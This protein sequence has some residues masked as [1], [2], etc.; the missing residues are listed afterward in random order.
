MKTKDL[1][2]KSYQLTIGWLYPELMSTYG[3]R[4]NITVL[5]KRCEWRGIN[6]KVV[7]INQSTNYQL[8]STCD[9]LFMGG[10]QDIQQEIVQK[11]LNGKKGEIIKNLVEGNT[12]GLFICG[13]YQFLGNYYKDAYGTEIKGLGIFNMHTESP[14][15]KPRLIGNIIVKPKSIPYSLLPTPYLTGFENHG[16]R[17]Y[18]SDKTQAFAKVIKGYGNNGDDMTEGIHFKNT[19][20]T[21]L[22][23]PIL[24]SNPKLA[25]YLIECALVKKYGKEIKLKELDDS[26]S[27]KAKLT[28]LK[29]LKASY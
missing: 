15:D 13:A 19:I 3:D 28:I 2:A 18:L 10:A 6:V 5:Q 9:L 8:L 1:K 26:F 25:D 20:G 4:G 11:D 23:G 27:E 12:P 29:R 7:R 16:G 14:R 24:P 21:Y 17:T 22:H